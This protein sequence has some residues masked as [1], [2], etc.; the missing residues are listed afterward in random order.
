LH[1]VPGDV[2]GRLFYVGC[3]CLSV[4]DGTGEQSGSDKPFDAMLYT[5][6]T[7]P[8]PA[9]AVVATRVKIM[10]AAKCEASD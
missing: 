9:S 3:A 6:L 4:Y 7:T 8:A 1:H 10:V 2:C 5:A